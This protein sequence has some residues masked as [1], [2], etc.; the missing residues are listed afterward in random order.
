MYY[1][2]LNVANGDKDEWDLF[3]MAEFRHIAVEQIK[4]K[5]ESRYPNCQF[6]HV[7]EPDADFWRNADRSWH[8]YFQATVQPCDMFYRLYLEEKETARRL[9][10]NMSYSD[11]RAAMQDE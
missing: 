11:Y 4:Q 1:C 3:A 7:E 5:L 10:R 9:A 6:E 2:Y 8:R